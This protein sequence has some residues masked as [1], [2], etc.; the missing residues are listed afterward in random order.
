[1]KLTIIALALLGLAACGGASSDNP[2]DIA[3][4]WSCNAGCNS[5]C[6]FPGTVTVQQNG[7]EI[8]VLSSAG[9]AEGNINNAGDF[10]FSTLDMKCEG[11]IFNGLLV[12]DCS[13]SGTSCQQVTYRHGD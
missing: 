2:P 11:N 4:F 3:G 7:D 5:I 13:V 12:A 9:T 8:L 6:Q 10:D 1:M